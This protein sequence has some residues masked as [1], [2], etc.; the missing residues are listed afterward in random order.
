MR[1]GLGARKPLRIS[2]LCAISAALTW[3]VG[4]SCLKIGAN[5]STGAMVLLLQVLAVSA[6]G[7]W[8]VAIFTAISA[9]L[10][11]SWYYVDQV[12]SLR[13][14]S[15]EGA[16]T[17]SMMLLTALTATQLSIR[18]Q[19]RTVEAIGRREEMERLQEFGNSLF[20]ADTVSEAANKAV[21][22]IER[23]F[24]VRGAEL[25]LGDGSPVFSA[26]NC[27]G[28]SSATT[29][30][31]S[32]SLRFFG[33]APSVEVSSAIGN[34]VRLVLERARSGEER[35]RS[36]A[37]RRGE[38]LRNVVLNALAHNFKTPLTSIKAAASILR[39]SPDVSAENTAELVAVIDEEADRL[40]LLIRES[41]DL[42]RIEAHQ[43]RPLFENCVLEDVAETVVARVAR[44]L[45][46]RTIHIEMPE[47]L[48]PV[49]GDRFL[50]GQMLM[51]VVDNAWKYS[52]P[53]SGIRISAEQVDTQVRLTVQNE[54]G[55]IPLEARDKLFTKFYRAAGTGSQVEGTGLG[56]AIAQAIAEAHGGKVWLD[57]L[58]QGPAFRFALPIAM[59]VTQIQGAS[60]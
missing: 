4:F 27:A 48:P 53:G 25:E 23:L 54:G 42:A 50:L 8:A 13:I 33:P 24:G 21:T 44:Y 56:L 26:G 3:T 16:V 7:E 22:Q 29:T 30:V 6:S 39:S 28:V 58:P 32:G 14:T 49:R 51:Q 43:A 31:G 1:L 9:S 52:K 38:E 12:G 40:D 46:G 17:F 47:S 41:L 10:A 20:S 36:E 35:A 37:S 60:N 34:L 55:E 59:E 45:A 2:A 57:M 18:A 5:R 11:F 19:R 15:G